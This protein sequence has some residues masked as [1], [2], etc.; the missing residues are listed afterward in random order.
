VIPFAELARAVAL[1]WK[2]IDSETK[3]YCVTVATILKKWHAKLGNK[4]EKVQYLSTRIDH[5]NPGSNKKTE[6]QNYNDMMKYLEPA[7]VRGTFCFPSMKHDL[8]E[9]VQ[10][11]PPSLIQH[12]CGM[13][14]LPITKGGDGNDGPE[15]PI[16]ANARRRETI[17]CMMVGIPSFQEQP[18]WQVNSPMHIDNGSLGEHRRSSAPGLLIRTQEK[19]LKAT[20]KAQD[21]VYAMMLQQMPP[22]LIQH[23]GGMVLD[24][25]ITGGD[26]YSGLESS[27]IANLSRRE[28][29]SNMMVGIPSFQ[30]QPICQE[31][32]PMHIEN[33]L[34]E[35]GLS[36]APEL[37][38]NTQEKQLNATYMVQELDISDCDVLGMWKSN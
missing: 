10:H 9:N 8:V 22:S 14:S 30:E 35:H 1:S 4:E 34:G 36:S 29:I 24:P 5:D 32:P 23:G 3:D 17:S 18:I 26:G 33:F 28:M 31:N 37:S 13:I 19:Q 6:P 27:I 16:I 20:Y 2:S 12:E 25:I 15:F 7:Q 11:M 38:I 21:C